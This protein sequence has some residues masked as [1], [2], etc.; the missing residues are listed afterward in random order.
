M[1]AIAMH[2]NSFGQTLRAF[3]LGW[4]ISEKH[5]AF[6]K[7]GVNQARTRCTVYVAPLGQQVPKDRDKLHLCWWDDDKDPNLLDLIPALKDVKAPTE[8]YS[9]DV[10][11]E[12][13]EKL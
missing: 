9:F 10:N 13:G 12:T 3:R 5:E 8:A 4:R 2:R 1:I 11:T 7:V 6:I